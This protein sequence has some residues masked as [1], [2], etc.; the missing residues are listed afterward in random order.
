VV[1]FIDKVFSFAFASDRAQKD[2]MHILR[3]ILA[4]SK[5]FW[6]ARETFR[7]VVST[8]YWTCYKLITARLGR[9]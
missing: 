6:H 9:L 7:L 2:D 4:T 5:N 3:N 8:M 1:T